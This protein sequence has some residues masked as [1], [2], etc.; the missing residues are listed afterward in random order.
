MSDEDPQFQGLRVGTAPIDFDFLQSLER[1]LDSGGES[2]E[3]GR[4][5]NSTLSQHSEEMADMIDYGIT[6]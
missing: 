4:N 6:S 1:S 3:N 5:V 2:A